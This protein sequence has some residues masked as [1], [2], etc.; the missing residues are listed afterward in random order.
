MNFPFHKNTKPASTSCPAPTLQP[1]AL[2]L[3]IAEERMASQ[4]VREYS[5]TCMRLDEEQKSWSLRRDQA[6]R[7]FCEALA[8]HADAKAQ[9]ARMSK[10]QSA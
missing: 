9:L 2:T 6:Y 5:A 4:A 8:R 10:P 3:A 1:D 7:S